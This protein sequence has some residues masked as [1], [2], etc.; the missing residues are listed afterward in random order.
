MCLICQEQSEN[1]CTGFIIFSVLS[2]NSD[3]LLGR[4]Y[5]QASARVPP[6]GKTENPS[7]FCFFINPQCMRL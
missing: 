4:I 5:S 1:V 3:E 7:L 2:L 6:R